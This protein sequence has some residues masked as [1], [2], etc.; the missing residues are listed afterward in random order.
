MKGLLATAMILTTA[1]AVAFAQSVSYPEILPEEI[2]EMCLYENEADLE[3]RLA[4]LLTGAT[5][6]V[7]TL[8]SDGSFE[9]TPPA[10]FVGFDSFTYRAVDGGVPSNEATVQ[11]L[12]RKLEEI[13][14]RP[15]L[16]ETRPITVDAETR[17]ALESLGYVSDAP[18]SITALAQFVCQ[19]ST[20]STLMCPS[21]V[22]SPSARP[23]NSST[24]I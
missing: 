6:G 19:F 9:Y 20:S 2:H 17:S 8:A 10:E 15:A 18:A 11:T 1:T 23:E 5:Y 21:A 16:Y 14:D 22:V 12:R 13:I 4:E 7:L 3:T 24:P